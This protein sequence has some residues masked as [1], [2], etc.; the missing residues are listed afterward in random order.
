[1]I[2]SQAGGSFLAKL[3]VNI[4]LYAH[5]QERLDWTRLGQFKVTKT[6]LTWGKQ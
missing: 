4:V 2:L 1:M 6:L 5:V 3:Q